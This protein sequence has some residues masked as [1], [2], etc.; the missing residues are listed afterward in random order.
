MKIEVFKERCIGAGNCLDVAPKYFALDA[1]GLVVANSETVAPGDEAEVTRAA[2]ICPA[3]AIE[4][5]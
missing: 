1:D 5:L 4:L 2:D 3:L